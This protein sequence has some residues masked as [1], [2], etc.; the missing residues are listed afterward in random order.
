[1]KIGNIVAIGATTGIGGGGGE[2]AFLT[3]SYAIRMSGSM[4]SKEYLLD[5]LQTSGSFSGSL[6][7][8]TMVQNESL[9]AKGSVI[10]YSVGPEPGAGGI[11]G[12]R[13]FRQE[14]TADVYD[15]EGTLTFGS[16]IKDTPIIV[17]NQFKSNLCIS[18]ND[19]RL[20]VTNSVGGIVDWSWDFEMLVARTTATSYASPV[21]DANAIPDLFGWWDATEG[22]YQDS[23]GTIAV[24]AD[25]QK[26]K[27]WA[28]KSPNEKNATYLQ[29]IYD[30]DVKAPTYTMVD[31]YLG[32]GP[33]VGFT[34]WYN[35]TPSSSTLRIDGTGLLASYTIYAVHRLYDLDALRTVLGADAAQGGILIWQQAN[36]FR[37]W[38]VEGYFGVLPNAPEAPVIAANTGYIIQTF[39][40]AGTTGAGAASETG[41]RAR[42]NGVDLPDHPFGNL[43]G[44]ATLGN[45]LYLGGEGSGLSQFGLKGNI[46]EVIIYNRVLT[47]L[48]RSVV[49]NYLKAKYAISY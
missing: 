14:Y 20:E 44:S 16:L 24:T 38:N 8:R 30:S 23:L 17:K 9:R 40:S 12:N 7:T 3:S 31:P 15:D 37:F 5:H 19:L 27:F 6:W 10:G 1:M 48:E 46:A 41:L 33:S 43:A 49:E 28:D 45:Y 35:D 29:G 42:I 11:A 25:G 2:G 47:S 21:F 34:A 26:V 36:Y 4:A 32:G 13:Y 18:G 39:R 22:L